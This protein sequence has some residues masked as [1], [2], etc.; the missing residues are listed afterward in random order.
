MASIFPPDMRLSYI[1]P[2]RLPTEKAHGYQIM[3][4]CE[5]L[6][7][8]GVAVD[9]I[10][11]DRR[12]P[13]GE[14][15]V[16]KYYD[17]PATFVM[18]RL[19]VF[20]L[21]GRLPSDRIAFRLMF[22]SFARSVRQNRFGLSVSD[23]WY[24]RD[25]ATAEVLLGLPNAKPV[26][27]ELHNATDSKRLPRLAGWIVISQGLKN[28]LLKQGVPEEKIR[29][30]HDGF[31]PFAFEHLS[32]KQDAREKLG[33]TQ[34]AFLVVYAGHL[35]PWK[36]VDGIASAFKNIPDGIELAV[37]GGYPSDIARVKSLAGETRRVR[38]VGQ[39]PR[40]EVSTWLAAAD[41]ALLP[42]SAKFE[43]GKSYTSPLKL[44]EY[45]AAGLPILASDVPSHHEILDTSV[46]RF[47]R[48]D[49]AQDFLKQLAAMKEAKFEPRVAK[50]R[51]QPYAWSE[52]GKKIAAFLGR[53]VLQY[54]P[55]VDDGKKGLLVIA[56]AVDEND[57]NLAFFLSWLREIASRVSVLHVAAW[58]VGAHDLPSNVHVH[59]MPKGKFRR[60]VALK[61]LSWLLRH[62]IDAVFVHML[63]PVAAVLAPFWRFILRKRVVLWYTHGSIPFLLRVANRFVH[64]IC[65]ATDESLRLKTA[66]KIVT[67]HG[68]D[69]G[70]FHPGD[71]P[72]LPEMITVGRVSPRKRLE[73]V[74][75]LA[76]AI[77]TAHPG[78]AFRLRIIGEAYLET[79][80]VY[81]ASLKKLVSDRR[82]GDLVTFEGAKL[83]NEL[84]AAYQHS[85]VFV[86][87]SATGSLDKAVLE[88]LACGTPV[89]AASPVFAGFEG[90]E[91]AEKD[92]AL[93]FATARLAHPR[94][95]PEARADVEAK[96]SLH[97]LAS[98][99]IIILFG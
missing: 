67:G 76:D 25:P 66:K 11:A 4:T 50:E 94:T 96:A 64:V 91:V 88:A 8:S 73:R 29:V 58:K 85:A 7:A 12:N 77:R 57:T 49:D 36:G 6:A 95:S 52:R 63:A 31:D 56:Q 18:R 98:R 40:A 28:Q 46:A 51:V 37:V 43:I 20:D 2:I 3:K 34:D 60:I 75:E 47:F 39:R 90:V 65:S 16:F 44:F 62:E 83:G 15:D 33:I 61:L 87:E 93:A 14:K 97:A 69:T 30:A 80:K 81:E 19:P 84:V 92:A 89:L 13:I 45:L 1:E 72:R 53:G 5:A 42:T 68:I 41:A 74:I 54:A 59:P 71:Q 55:T 70:F 27:L 24:A 26:F 10:V 17:L 23:A 9:L 78:L 82:L 35:Y 32:S 38:F 21:I 48:P 79:D 86:T 99:L 22:R